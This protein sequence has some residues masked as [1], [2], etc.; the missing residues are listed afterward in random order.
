VVQ[1]ALQQAQSVG[2]AELMA[3]MQASLKQLV[4]A[5]KELNDQFDAALQQLTA[6]LPVVQ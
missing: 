3:G 2:A 5:R 6:N 4:A 1:A